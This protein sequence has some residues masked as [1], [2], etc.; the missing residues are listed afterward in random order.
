MRVLAVVSVP[1][2]RRVWASWVR[3]ERDFSEVGR[4]EL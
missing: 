3:R 4:E 2:P 1:A